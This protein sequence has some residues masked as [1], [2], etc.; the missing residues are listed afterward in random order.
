MRPI[1]HHL[2]ALGLALAAGL[3]CRAASAAPDQPLS[4]E[5]RAI[6]VTDHRGERVDTGLRFVDERG[7]SV[8]LAD[9][10]DGERPVALTLNYYRCRVVCSVQLNGLA[11]ALAEVDWEPGEDFRLVTLSIDP[12]ET[13]ADARKKRGSIADAVGKGDDIDWA[14]LTGSELEIRALASQV[15]IA[16]AYDAEQDQYA[17]PGVVVFLTP[18]GR[19]SRYV[20]GLTYDPL[21][22]KLG[23]YEAADGKIGG[24][25]EQLYLSCFSYDATIGQ[26]GPFAMGIMRLGGGLTALLLGGVMFFLWRRERRQATLREG[27]VVAVGDHEGP[28]RTD[29]RDGVAAPGKVEAV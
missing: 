19:V 22:V 9:F 25:V 12:H 15:G 8:A 17:H 7:E 14:F 11:D 5:M 3:G 13:P 29:S 10:F 23:L 4:P 16:Y 27:S 6:E 21:D 26:Y 24:P 20:Y 28:G 18:D 1:R 2:A